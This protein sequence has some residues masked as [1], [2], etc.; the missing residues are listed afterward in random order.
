[1]TR[2][3]RPDAYMGIVYPHAVTLHFFVEIERQDFGN[4]K[5]GKPSIYRKAERMYGYYDTDEC[6][7]EWGFRKFRIIFQVE[8]ETRAR[9][10][11]NALSP[12]RHKMFWV[13]TPGSLN[14]LTP[15]DS[16]VGTYSFLT[17]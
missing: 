16:N 13:G 15:E 7:R 4:V 12:I 9:H 17:I 14:Y 2:K 10:L 6:E 11:L 8:N 1:M 3:R 5:D